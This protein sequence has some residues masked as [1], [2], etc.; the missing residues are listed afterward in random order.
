M[1]FEGFERRRWLPPLLGSLLFLAMFGA[2]FAYALPREVVLSLLQPRLGRAGIGLDARD[3]GILFPAGIS[4]DNGTITLP[5]RPSQLPVDRAFARIDLLWLFR[6]MPLH[7][8]ATRGSGVLEYRG[9]G[10][11]RGRITATGLRTEDLSSFLPPGGL[12]MSVDRGEVEWRRSAKGT[13]AGS[14]SARFP[15]L[16]IP[17][18]A[19]D[20]PIREALLRDVTMRFTLDSGS[21][22]VS[23]LTGTFEGSQVEG[24]GEIARVDS[25]SRATITFHL[26]IRN[27]YE[28]NVATL[29]NLVSKNAKNA[30]LRIFGPLFSPAGEFQFF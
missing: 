3:A 28:G 10:T 13:A 4:I 24:T 5:G 25:L 9:S 2:V 26:K 14:G 27:P 12:E 19:P 6:G 21:L 11:S 16:K 20:S 8:G 29:F 23:S 18:P 1:T 15:T 17:I 7:A 22:R 30:N